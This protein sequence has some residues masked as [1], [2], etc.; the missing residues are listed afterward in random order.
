MTGLHSRDTLQCNTMHINHM[1]MNNISQRLHA[2]A[3]H[4]CKSKWVLHGFSGDTNNKNS[5]PSV[6]TRT[7]ARRSDQHIK[8]QTSGTWWASPVYAED[9]ASEPICIRPRTIA[10][11]PRRHSH[12]WFDSVHFSFHSQIIHFAPALVLL[13]TL[14]ADKDEINMT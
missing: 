5:R 11:E 13:L 8:A 9:P 14:T 12:N 4:Y 7:F 2:E 10:V 6:R 3:D 1:L